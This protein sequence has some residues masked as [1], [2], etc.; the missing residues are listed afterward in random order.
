MAA[1]F[2]VKKLI[3]TNLI[4]IFV[5]AK[6]TRSKPK[7]ATSGTGGKRYPCGGKVKKG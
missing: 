4:I 5:M 6:T 2:K 1:I 3:F 7:T